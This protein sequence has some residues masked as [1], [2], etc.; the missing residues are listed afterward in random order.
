MF[1]MIEALGAYHIVDTS[2][3][4]GVTIEQHGRR[5]IAKA[6]MAILN[7]KA[8]KAAKAANEEEAD[9]P[10]PEST[11]RTAS[12]LLAGSVRE[13]IGALATGDYDDQI[14]VLIA[15]EMEGLS[16][17]SALKVLRARQP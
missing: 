1:R 17:K 10:M 13:L 2:I 6:R 5:D 3:P 14:A 7:R 9:A 12:G 4:G 11:A 8:P 16:R 15:E